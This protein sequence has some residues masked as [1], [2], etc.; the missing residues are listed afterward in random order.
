MSAFCSANCHIQLS[1]IIIGE[2]LID[3]HSAFWKNWGFN[4]AREKKNC[5][6]LSVI[7]E[8]RADFKCLWESDGALRHSQVWRRSSTSQVNLLLIFIRISPQPGWMKPELRVHQMW[9]EEKAS[10]REVSDFF[11]D[12]SCRRNWL[13]FLVQFGLP[14][15]QGVPHWQTA[16]LT[17][18]SWMNRSSRLQVEEAKPSSGILH[19]WRLLSLFILQPVVSFSCLFYIQHLRSSYEF[20]SW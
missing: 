3:L 10:G 11:R 9:R 5:S 14:R 15:D 18:R 17:Q 2:R 20:K 4:R 16:V 8:K 19:S 7:A 6:T 13:Q 12:A 1:V